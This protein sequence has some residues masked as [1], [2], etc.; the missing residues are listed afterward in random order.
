MEEEILENHR[1]FLE[2]KALYKKL[3][4]DIDRERGWIIK[5]AQPISGKILE[6]GTGKGYFALLLAQAGYHFTSIDIS[7]E[8]QQYARL[9]LKYFSLEESVDFRIENA[10]QLSFKNSSYDLIFSINT[11]HHLKDPFTVLDEFVRVVTPTGKI[12]LADFSTEGFKIVAR[13][14][15]SENRVHEVNHSNLTGLEKNLREEGFFVKKYRS[16]FQ[17]IL[18]ADHQL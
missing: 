16:K 6:V 13:M 14:H 9:N 17:Q 10:E 8:E 2:R 1:R 3:G 7:Q 15:Q 11:F 5:K 4:Y 18:I 12:V